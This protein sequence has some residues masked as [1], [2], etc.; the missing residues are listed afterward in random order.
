MLKNLND[1]VSQNEV[2]NIIKPK[3]AKRKSSKSKKSQKKI[4][5]EDLPEGHFEILEFGPL[6][7]SWISYQDGDKKVRA[8]LLLF[9]YKNLP[10]P[11]RYKYKGR[12]NLVQLTFA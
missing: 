11:I 12:N 8:F 5:E 2:E 7:L 10:S 3:R 9:P 1:F 6:Y 4:V